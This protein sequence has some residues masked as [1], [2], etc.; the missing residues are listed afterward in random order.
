MLPLSPQAVHILT[1]QPTTP[2]PLTVT[3]KNL[4]TTLPL[5][6]FDIW[7]EHSKVRGFVNLDQHP[8]CDP[9]IIGVELQPG[10][11]MIRIEEYHYSQLNSKQLIQI[12]KLASVPSVGE[13]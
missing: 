9:Q 1:H 13:K 4:K 7:D 12:V 6:S 8:E 3:I 5:I 2:S 11:F 10:K